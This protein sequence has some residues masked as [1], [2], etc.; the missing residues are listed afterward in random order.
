M[1]KSGAFSLTEVILPHLF[2]CYAFSASIKFTE[3]RL[4]RLSFA[5]TMT[6]VEV[7]CNHYA[8][9]Y[10]DSQ[11]FPG[12]RWIMVGGANIAPA[13][14]CLLSAQHPDPIAL[15]RDGES[16]KLQMGG[17][18]DLQYQWYAIQASAGS[19]IWQ[20]MQEGERASSCKYCPCNCTVLWTGLTDLN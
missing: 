2:L 9:T 7:V 5:C 16:Q 4:W 18:M 6:A 8:I 10:Q 14:D 15:H 20:P 13:V 12:R 11:D 1:E 17:E 3:T 19:Q